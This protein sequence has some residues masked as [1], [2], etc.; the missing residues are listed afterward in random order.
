LFGLF[1]ATV[2]VSGVATQATAAPIVFTDRGAWEL[3]VAVAGNE[4]FSSTIDPLPLGTT[5]LGVV[6]V[7]VNG[8]LSAFSNVSGGQ[9]NGFIQNGIDNN[10]SSI[11]FTL[12][13]AVN[14]WGADFTL[15]ATGD[16]LIVTVNGNAYNLGTQLINQGTGFLGTIE[17]APFTTLTMTTAAFTS[18]GENYFVDDLSFGDSQTAVPEP[19]TLLLLAS[20]LG[21]AAR[22]RLRRN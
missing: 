18:I 20:G 9:F 16:V 22:R 15:A 12:P 21:V 10:V 11:V 6:D 13:Q 5:D 19:A 17:D 1:A 4:T 14:A 2:M 7:T 8:T 3:A